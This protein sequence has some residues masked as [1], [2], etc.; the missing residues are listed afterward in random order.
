M[1]NMQARLGHSLLK[2]MVELRQQK[3]EISLEDLGEMFSQV[4]SGF[5]P[6]ASASDQFMHQEI[7][8][9]AKYISDAKKEIF[10]I[11]VNDKSEDAITDASAHLGE[12]IKATE[13]ASNTIM[14]AADTIQNE[15]AGIGEKEQ[16]ITDAVMKIYEACNFQDI[17]GQRISKVITLLQ[18]IEESINKLNELFG[19]EADIAAASQTDGE[20]KD[21]ADLMNGPQLSSEAASQE[22]IDALFASLGGNN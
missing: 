3:G 6:P 13:E 19:N 20:V 15:V 1:S 2:N 11:S 16:P 9:L 17:T 14:D 10:S 21:D 5:N 22:E 4:A 8:R 7:A 12:V 18:T